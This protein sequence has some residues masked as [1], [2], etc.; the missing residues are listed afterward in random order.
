VLGYTLSKFIGIKAVSEVSRDHRAAVIL[1]LIGTAQAALLLFGILPQ[2]W[3]V[4][5]LFIN[6]LPLGMVFGLV[7]GFLEGRRVTELLT[8]VL[9]SSF[10]VAGGVTKSVGTW[11]LNDWQVPPRWMPFF[12]G[13]IFLPPLCLFVWMLSRIP[14]PSVR[15]VDLRTERTTMDHHDRARLFGR[16][17]GGLIC[18]GGMFLLVT[19]LRSVRDDF[20]PEIWKGLGL[21]RDPAIFTQTELI[22]GLSVPASCALGIFIRGNRRAFFTAVF[23]ALI[24]LLL[25]AFTLIGLHFHRISPFAFMVLMGVGLYLPYVTVHTTIFERLVAMTRDRA[26]IGYLM[27]LVD[28]FGYLGYVA[29]M[30]GK[31]LFKFEGNFLSFFIALSWFAA[32][33]GSACTIG[34]WI[35][36]DRRCPR[37][38]A[39]EVNYALEAAV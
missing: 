35:Y 29:V 28:A 9:C 6:G 32:G 13:L 1:V 14:A 22:V 21:T 27:Y 18:I 34:C 2:P 11:L 24:G 25:V 37:A 5:C 23:A 19:I 33:V 4:I 26:T 38:G 8:A 31:T 30:V 39:H 15:D 16:Y 10:I 36:F 20:A 3:N 12:S 17:A 7:L